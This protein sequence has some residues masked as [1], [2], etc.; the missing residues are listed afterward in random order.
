MIFIRFD[1]HLIQSRRDILSRAG[2][3]LYP[4]RDGHSIP[5]VMDTLSRA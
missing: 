5:S 2:E 1:K 3:T 4:E